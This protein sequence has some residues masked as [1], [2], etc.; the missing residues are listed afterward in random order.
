MVDSFV[1]K[2]IT[3]LTA[4][5]TAADTDL[6]PITDSNGNFFKMT[7][8]KLKQL[9]LGTKDI[10]GVGD[11]TVTGAI[12]ELNTKIKWTNIYSGSKLLNSG[13]PWNSTLAFADFQRIK[14]TFVCQGYCFPAEL[15]TKKTERNYAFAFGYMHTDGI[16]RMITVNFATAGRYLTNV[17][18]YMQ[19]NTGT[20]TDISANVYVAEIYGSNN[21]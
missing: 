8:Q 14:I 6:V 4:K 1:S 21:L 3:E 16:H 15:V 11:G 20:W 10:S 18:C 9:L 5:T 19:Q 17:K 13:G 7:W 2:L 12:S